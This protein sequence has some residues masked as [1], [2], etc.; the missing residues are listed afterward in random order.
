MPGNLRLPTLS[1]GQNH[2]VH[3]FV[4]APQASM[5]GRK[6]ECTPARKPGQDVEAGVAPPQRPLSLYLNLAHGI[7]IRYRRCP[8]TKAVRCGIGQASPAAVFGL[9]REAVPP[10]A[11]GCPRWL[12][13]G[14][15]RVRPRV[16]P[17]NRPHPS[18]FPPAYRPK[19]PLSPPEYPLTAKKHPFC[20]PP[21]HC[22]QVKG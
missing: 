16:F 11:G 13:G 18:P 22:Q 15:F 3:D 4:G 20:R 5:D 14:R 9:E 17:E 19:H 1:G 12:T 8:C 6:T 21:P 7:S 10:M 2:A